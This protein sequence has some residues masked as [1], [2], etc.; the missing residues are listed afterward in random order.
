[1][2]NLSV[3]LE[4]SELE[5]YLAS[6]PRKIFN[7]QRSAIRTTT[8]FADKEM[9]RRLRVAT[10]LP[11]SVFKVYRIR[12]R[13]SD[14]RGSVWLGMKAVKAKFAGKIRQEDFGASAGRY[15]WPGG[16]IVSMHEE[17]LSIFKRKGEK[18]L[19]IVEQVVELPMAEAVG[20]EVF[21]LT[22]AELQRR[23]L[24]KLE[25]ALR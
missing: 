22:Q 16:F 23:Y 17:H 5:R 8:T 24:E 18:R 3:K 11:A 15:Y 12:K 9:K 10:G 6:T 21:E 4:S 25:A 13:S 7:A 20:D 14:N 19:P 1:M 2:A